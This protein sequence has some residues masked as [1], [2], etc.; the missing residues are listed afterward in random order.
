MSGDVTLMR[1]ET[2]ID[3][4]AAA[5]PDR[6]ALRYGECSWT[7]REIQAERDR[8]AGILVEAGLGVGDRVLVAERITAD[9]PLTYLAC[10]QAGLVLASLSPLLAEPEIAALAERITPR[11]VFTPT[12]APHPALPFVP[13]LALSLPGTPGAAA[14]EEAYRR[15]AAGAVTDPSIIRA[16]SGSTGARPK[17]IVRAHQSITWRCGESPWPAGPTSVYS[18]LT[19]TQLA[20]GEFCR[21][22]VLGTTFVLPVTVGVAGLEEEL[23]AQ[24][25]TA[26]YS[27]PG[28]MTAL[29]QLTTPPPA[30]LHLEVIRTVG[31]PLPLELQQALGRRY[32]AVVCSDYG[33]SECTGITGTYG[34]E[35]PPGSV[36]QARPGVEVRL[37]DDDGQ[38]VAEG[39]IGEFVVRSP[40]VMLGYLDDPVLTAAVLRD[41][42]IYTG[43]YAHR[44]T[45]G[46]YFIHGRRNLLINVAGSKVAP[47]EVEAVLLRHP[48]VR[49]VVALAMP[50][51]LRGQVVRAVIVPEGG[52]PSVAELRRFCRHHLASYKVP[53]AIE[54]RDSLPHSA[55][56]KVLRPQV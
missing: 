26:I 31:A 51:R 10:S 50:H 12:G 28:M 32:G 38:P 7:F 6:V 8:R 25:V 11:L 48:G 56:G 46:N 41:G 37:L 34:A 14:V 53:R 54:F 16:T 33:Q 21:A 49:E 43:D 36:G 47:E 15:S 9:Y 5:F 18:D 1:I 13:T 19:S 30:G 42:W 39:E 44:D 4:P 55:L 22:A 35:T 27:N 52:P 45:V 2:T 24:G 17:L 23:A 20:M 3:A 29:M 40:A